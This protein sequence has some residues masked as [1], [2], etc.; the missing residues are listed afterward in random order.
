MRDKQPRM[1]RALLARVIDYSTYAGLFVLISGGLRTR[2]HSLLPDVN[3]MLYGPLFLPLAACLV[4]G[5]RPV[6]SRVYEWRERLCAYI[7]ALPPHK[8]HRYLGISIAGCV[9]CHALVVYLRHFSFQT[10]MDLAIY[11]NACR[12]A[13]FSTMKGDVWLFADH[14][15]PDLLLFT[16]LC[17]AFTPAVTLLGVQ[18]L[19]FGVGAIG[20]FALARQQNYSPSLA[21]F[22]ALLYL[23]YSNHVT[24]AY[25]DFHLLALTLGLVPWLWWALQAKRYGWVIGLAIF[26]LGLKESVPLTL[27]GFGAY[28]MLRRGDATE[29]K[30]GF[31]FLAL[32]LLSFVVIM[33]FVYPYFRQGQETM[34]FAKYYGHLGR[35]LSEFVVTFV[36]RPSYFATEL[37]RP[38]KVEYVAMLVA[39]FLFYPLFRP[40]YLL[41]VL[42]AVLVN[43]LSNDPNLLGRT[44]HYEAEISPALFAMAVIAFTA[45]RYRPLWLAVLLVAFMAPSALGVARWNVPTSA[46]RRLLAQLAEHVPH[47][48]AI[49]APQRIAAHLTDRPRLYM[50]DYWQMEEDWKRADIVV[51]GYHGDSM[52]WYTTKIFEQEKFPKMLPELRMIYQDPK[53][54]QFRLY[55]VDVTRESQVAEVKH[56]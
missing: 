17:R 1:L 25:Y 7:D 33:K 45:S 46:Q 43:I 28:L 44:Y 27:M 52:G 21:W 23:G 50:F 22:V 37:L 13:L 14:F 11:A 9:A 8:L 36:T 51:L 30:I 32:G 3:L 53:D 38:E 54:P 34:Y 16:P 26:Y 55:E 41:P 15:E 18:T 19:A 2:R 31:G 10:G 42:P 48:K 56:D 12:G 47:D 6:G 4:L 20:I 39:P 5:Y 24:L 40:V 49:A 29:K 35:N